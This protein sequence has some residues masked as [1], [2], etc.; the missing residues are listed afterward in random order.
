MSIVNFLCQEPRLTKHRVNC[1]ICCLVLDALSL[2]LVLLQAPDHLKATYSPILAYSP[3]VDQLNA[4]LY[5]T[6]STEY[7]L[8]HLQ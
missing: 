3:D 1:M 8:E 6:L 7:H 2:T 4:T 5:Q